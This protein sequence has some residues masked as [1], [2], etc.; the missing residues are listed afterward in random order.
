M[1][2]AGAGG[3]ERPPRELHILYS[4]TPY[5][6]YLAYSDTLV[7]GVPEA[8][9]PEAFLGAACSCGRV[10][11]YGFLALSL[12]ASAASLAG[13]AMSGSPVAL[14]FLVVG[15]LYWFMVRRALRPGGCPLVGPARVPGW[16]PGLVSE[17]LGA[18]EACRSGRGPCRGV[19]YAGGLRYGFYAARGRLARLL[20]GYDIR[21]ASGERLPSLG[22]GRDPCLASQ[23]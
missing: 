10:L 12:L 5:H 13:L 16:L 4:P 3:G 11:G 22:L 14:V 19:I 21:L 15:F 6:V 17:A 7:I 18:L 8:G 1:V 9:S 20:L 2:A 23:G